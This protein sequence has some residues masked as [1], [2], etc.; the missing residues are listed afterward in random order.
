[1]N[2]TTLILVRHGQTDWN[3]QHRFQGQ[4][5]VPLNDHGRAQVAAAAR[6]LAGVRPVALYCSDLVRCRET[7]E[8]LGSVLGVAPTIAP[9]LRERSFG[10]VE[11]LT[12][13]E[14]VARFPESWAQW[15]SNRDTWI[16]PGGE[17]AGEAW[18]RVLGFT[19]KLWQRHEGETVV[20]A[21]HGGPIKAIISR[22]LGAPMSAR[23]AFA[24][25]NGGITTITRNAGGPTVAMLNETCHLGEPPGRVEAD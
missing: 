15:S 10:Q 3:L 20:I 24:V 8:I 11:G 5:D 7:A 16:P 6:R 22:A 12:R 2:E 17:S 1:M 4:C 13:E 21:G 9:E 14:A 18:G 23:F 19:E 25:S